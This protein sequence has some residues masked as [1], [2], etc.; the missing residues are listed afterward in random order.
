M[1]KYRVAGRV[2]L[3]NGPCKITEK[4]VSL[5]IC[6][7]Y[8]YNAL[9]APNYYPTGEIKYFKNIIE[10]PKDALFFVECDID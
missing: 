9:V 8:P 1:L 10:V 5:D 3:F 4:I 7:A 2:E 6:S